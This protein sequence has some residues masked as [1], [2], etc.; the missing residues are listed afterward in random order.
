MQLLRW[1]RDDQEIKDK[2]R[3]LKVSLQK[4]I[5]L[6]CSSR[7]DKIVSWILLLVSYFRKSSTTCSFSLFPVNLSYLSVLFFCTLL[8]LTRNETF[9]FNHFCFFILQIEKPLQRHGGRLEHNETYCGSCFG[10]ETVLLVICY[11]L[12]SFVNL[13]LFFA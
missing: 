12:F 5:F 11:P 4:V 1:L 6:T 7:G 3:V 8:F 9:L 13:E 10:A 2:T